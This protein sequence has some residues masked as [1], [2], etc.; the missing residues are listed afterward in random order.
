MKNNFLFEI[1]VEDKHHRN[2][3]D[4]VAWSPVMTDG[5]SYWYMY[6]VDPFQQSNNCAFFR[7]KQTPNFS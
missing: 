6:N 1:D 4:P 5:S 2:I 7:C 3:H